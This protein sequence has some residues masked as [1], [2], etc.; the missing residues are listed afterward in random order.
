M[1]SDRRK[2]QNIYYLMKHRCL[3]NN[4]VRY[5]SYG[6]RGIKVC[7]H[8][9]NFDNFYADMGDRPSPKHSLDRIDNNGN[10]CKENCRWATNEEQ[11]N[12]SRRNNYITY[13]GETKTLSQWIKYFNLKSSTI[14]QRFY[15]Y[16]WD[17]EKCFNF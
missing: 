11:V 16:K 12:N 7:E 8:W 1:A 10:Y 6:G 14:R 5:N 17:I 2:L 15:V 13:K 4:D 9:M 3:N